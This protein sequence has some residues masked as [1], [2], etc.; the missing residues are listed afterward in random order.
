M[1]VG[2]FD[3]NGSVEQILTHFIHGK[4]YPYYT[5]DEMVKQMP[6]LKKKF[7]SFKQYASATIND[8][9][10]KSTLEKATVFKANT[11][12][13]VYVENIGNAKF[14]LRRLPAG[15]QF[16]PVYAAVSDD[17]NDDGN[18][19]VFLAGNFY[20]INIQMGRYDASYGLL[21]TGDGKGNFKSIPSVKSGFS[22]NG[23]VRSIYSARI[24]GRVYYLCV[25]N[26]DTVKVFT[27]N[28]Q[29]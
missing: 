13:S 9:F 25:R 15:V 23:E 5:R 6:V 19:D 27:R 4:E 14:K 7:L 24:D 18:L 28:Q 2:D 16:S 29:P 22:V 1:Y 10:D 8:V 17:F 21:L 12:E 20:P 11:F 26:N 3:N